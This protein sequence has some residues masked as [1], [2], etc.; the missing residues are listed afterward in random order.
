VRAA[1]LALALAACQGKE[2]APKPAPKPSATAVVRETKVVGLEVTLDRTPLPLENAFAFSRGGAALHIMFSTH[3]LGCEHLG[4]PGFELQEG[5]LA[6]D[7][8]MAPAL[9]PDGSERWSITGSHLGTMARQGDLGTV[10]VTASDPHKTVVAK[11]KDAKLEFPPNVIGL[12]GAVSAQPCSI[13]PWSD[14]ARVRPQKDLQLE[15]AG[16]RITIHGATLSPGKKGGRVLILTSEP[17]AC[18]SGA[19][20]SDF[21]FRY[22]IGDDGQATSLRVSGYR[23]T[24]ELFS[25]E[26]ATPVT[27]KIGEAQSGETEVLLTTDLKIGGY[28]L[29]VDGKLAAE[30]CEQGV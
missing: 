30:V 17:Q 15:L 18:G 10:E 24:R 29:T 3:P 16:K 1:A 13:L 11:F 23:L 9:R 25:R 20:G 4:G 27:V 2:S 26:V 21:G 8:T 7:V 14:K 12:H 5:E 28:L 19:Q 22:E 6:F